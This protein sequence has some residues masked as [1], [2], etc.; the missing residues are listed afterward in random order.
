MRRSLNVHWFVFLPKPG[1]CDDTIGVLVRNHDEWPQ[2]SVDSCRGPTVELGANYMNFLLN[3]TLMQFNNKSWGTPTMQHV[4]RSGN[5]DSS[6]YGPA[7]AARGRRRP[8]GHAPPRPQAE[9]ES[10]PTRALQACQ[11]VAPGLLAILLVA[12]N[13][14]PAAHPS[15]IREPPEQARTASGRG[16]RGAAE[17]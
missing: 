13:A 1:T 4:S 15:L 5:F 9:C 17:Q 3:H 2:R 6:R 14:V 7:R 12:A 10:V 16:Q 11:C 8:G